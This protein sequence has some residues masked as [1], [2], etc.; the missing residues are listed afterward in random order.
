MTLDTWHLSAQE[1]NKQKK[2]SKEGVCEKPVAWGETE[3]TEQAN[4]ESEKN[5][6][7]AAAEEAEEA[8][9]EEEEEEEAVGHRRPFFYMYVWTYIY[10]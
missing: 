4:K 2:Q 5:Q 1:G 8:E 7:Q 10:I 9:E 6:L 3:E